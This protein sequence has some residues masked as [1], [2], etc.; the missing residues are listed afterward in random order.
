MHTFQARI[1]KNWIMRCVDVPEEIVQALGGGRG[2]PVLARYCG[3]TTETTVVPGGGGKGRLILRMDILRPAGL[4]TG[5][6]VEVSLEPDHAS[7]EPELPP[8]FQRALRFRPEA[9]EAFQRAPVSM[10]RQLM[11]YL[12]AAKREET[13]A[14]RI[15]RIIERLAEGTNG[16]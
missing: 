10:R 4:E 9:A 5:D 15:E 1:C 11:L 3:E 2:I 13:R 7:R 14:G 6:T 16:A 8:D 12:E